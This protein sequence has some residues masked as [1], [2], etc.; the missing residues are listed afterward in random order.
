[1]KRISVDAQGAKHRLSDWVGGAASRC[2]VCQTSGK[3]PNLPVAG[4]SSA[5]SFDGTQAGPL[6]LGN[7]I[8]LRAMDVYP[9]YP[10]V[11]RVGSKNPLEVGDAL[12]QSDG[13]GRRTGK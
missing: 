8:A 10:L 3:M 6:L 11:A 13:R 2:E 5:P 4:T 12:G 1:M 9:K 7:V